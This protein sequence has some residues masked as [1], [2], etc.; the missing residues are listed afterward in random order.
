MK[1]CAINE[2]VL[3]V[4]H[5]CSWQGCASCPFHSNGRELHVTLCRCT[6]STVQF[7]PFWRTY[8]PVFC[9]AHAVAVEFLMRMTCQHGVADQTGLCLMCRRVAHDSTDLAVS[10]TRTIMRVLWRSD[11]NKSVGGPP[12]RREFFALVERHTRSVN[13]Q[14]RML[15]LMMPHMHNCC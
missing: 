12:K 6:L 2:S 4:G 7:R 13:R 3:L 1:K 5:M 14:R 10:E 9:G 11:S 15:Y 8:G